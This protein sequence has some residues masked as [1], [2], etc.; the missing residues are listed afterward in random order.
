MIN[1]IKQPSRL[2]NRPNKTFRNKKNAIYFH[3]WLNSKLDTA[4]GE[5]VDKRNYPQY[6]T[7]GEVENY[8]RGIKY[9]EDRVVS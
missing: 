9:I 7:K 8:G 1:Y 5:L 3:G 2:E 4:K 6:K